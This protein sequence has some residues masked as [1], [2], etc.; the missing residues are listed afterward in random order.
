[1]A[2]FETLTVERRGGVDLVTL[3]R[4]DVLNAFDDTMREELKSVWRAMRTDDDV[5]CAVVTGAGDRAFCVGLDR[6]Q[7]MVATE[8]SLFGTSN[9]FMYDDPGDDLGPK[10]CD[11]WKPVIAAV[12]GMAC[13]GAFYIL[14]ECDIIVASQTATFFD[15]HVTYG[16][17][18]VYEPMKMMQ[19]MTLGDVL[20]MSLLGA[21][22][23]IGAETA[24]RIGLVSE[25]V[26]PEDLLDSAMA[27]AEI[28]ASQPAAA[29]QTTL[30]AVWAAVEA[31]PSQALRLAPSILANGTSAAALAEGQAT[32]ASGKRV[33][34]RV[35]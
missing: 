6:N 35:R 17:A 29:V 24:E 22:E 19:R 31:T 20:R 16:M 33:Q 5:R 8:G 25:V 21:H 18:A 3:N 32:F 1:V 28:I 9:A 14:A 27:L 23:V 26:A 15:P 2:E 12:N 13:G 7:P 4:P 11:L 10:A 30:R 34:R